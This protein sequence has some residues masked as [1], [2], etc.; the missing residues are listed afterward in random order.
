VVDDGSSDG[1]AMLA[2]E[3]G[4]VVLENKGAKGYIGA[5]KTGFDVAKHDVLV[6][7]DAD[8]EH[9]PKF[10]LK[11]TEPI[12]SN[13]ADLVLGARKKIDRMGERIITDLAR[14]VVD[15]SDSGTGMRAMRTDLARRLNLKGKCICG[16][17]VLEPFYL[18]ARIG[19]VPIENRTIDKSRRIAWGH[20]KQFFIVL[21]LI[22]KMKM[23][24]AQS[25]DRA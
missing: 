3:K 21:L 24:K 6:T 16:I 25:V 4:A 8:G 20:F 13:E 1:T 9:D 11:L 22:L 12:F 7:M 17:S 15:V 10:I 14:L 19:E 23:G 2:K 18:G 5:I